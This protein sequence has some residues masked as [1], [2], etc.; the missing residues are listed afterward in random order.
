MRRRTLLAAAGVAAGLRSARA[1]DAVDVSLV[2]AVDVSRSIDEDEARLQ[3]EGYRVAVADPIVVAAIRGGMIGAVGVAYVEW[4]G[5]E[6][7]RTVIPWRRIASQADADGW[8]AELAQAPRASLS[9]TS[10]SGAIRHARQVME[11]CPW[12]ATRKVID[13]SGDGV[14]NSGP[15]ADQQRDAALAEGITINGLPII[16]DRPTFGRLPPVPLD[17]YYRENVIGG[18]VH[19]M[20][21]AEDFESFG[22]AVKRKLIR[23]IAGLPAGVIPA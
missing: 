4:A 13:V 8:A 16:N 19:F 17:D 2:M 10:I 1:E 22:V 14:N 11:E 3:R 12:E 9:W 15:P 6:Y 18:P 7:Q 21:V 5:I 23:E 20:I